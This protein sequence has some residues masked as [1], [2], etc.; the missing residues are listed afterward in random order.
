[1]RAVEIQKVHLYKYFCILWAFRIVSPETISVMWN[2]HSSW[3][4]LPSG[5]CPWHSTKRPGEVAGDSSVARSCGFL[6]VAG[7]TL[8]TSQN[9]FGFLCHPLVSFVIRMCNESSVLGLSELLELWRWVSNGFHPS[10][11]TPSR[12]DKCMINGFKMLPVVCQKLVG[13]SFSR[14]IWGG[15]SGEHEKDILNLWGETCEV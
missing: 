6:C 5:F 12:G 3:Q 1:M 7:D 10:R 13:Q 2:I 15:W 14:C 4:K 9:P 11:N 8:T